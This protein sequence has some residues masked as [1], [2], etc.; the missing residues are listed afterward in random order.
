M[1]ELT[2]ASQEV[3]SPKHPYTSET[4]R[5]IQ[6]CL[7]GDRSYSF[8]SI[9]TR[10]LRNPEEYSYLDY[11]CLGRARHLN[12]IDMAWCV[13]LSEYASSDSPQGQ[14]LA[15][16]I[17]SLNIGYIAAEIT[18]RNEIRLGKKA[19]RQWSRRDENHFQDRLSSIHSASMACAEYHPDPNVREMAAWCAAHLTQARAHRMRLIL[20]TPAPS[21]GQPPAPAST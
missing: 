16:K 14:D 21:A 1:S 15:N 6:A 11:M 12:P 5:Q 17:H 7:E 9:L 8:F 2:Q 13:D 3:F 4:T 19:R 18:T 10:M 20:P